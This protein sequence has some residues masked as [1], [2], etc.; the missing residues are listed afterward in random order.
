MCYLTKS[1]PWNI[2][3]VGNRCEYRVTATMPTFLALLQRNIMPW[4]NVWHVR[5][6]VN[7]DLIMAWG[8]CSCFDAVIH[9]LILVWLFIRQC[10]SLTQ[11]NHRGCWINPQSRHWRI[12]QDS[13][14]FLYREKDTVTY[15][16]FIG[17]TPTTSDGPPYP[18]ETGCDWLGMLKILWSPKP[19]IVP[20]FP[21]SQGLT[22]SCS[23]G[24]L[25]P[26]MFSALLYISRPRTQP[27][28]LYG[29]RERERRQRR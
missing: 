26:D 22:Y 10:Q 17:M 23:S 6:E 21:N 9:S 3:S 28:L 7:W 24:L 20:S 5:A 2:Y 25:A 29:E 12:K 27:Q 11:H 1:L 18:A 4:N 14:V 8:P 13:L 15:G 16:E 19:I